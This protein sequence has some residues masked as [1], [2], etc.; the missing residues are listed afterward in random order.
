M[1]SSAITANL[2]R[3][4]AIFVFVDHNEGFMV[5]IVGAGDGHSAFNISM[6]TTIVAAGAG[7]SD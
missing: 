1:E 2:L 3:S 4:R 7:V 6:M 5:D